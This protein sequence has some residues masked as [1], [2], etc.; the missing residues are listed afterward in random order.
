MFAGA[1]TEGYTLILRSGCTLSTL[2]TRRNDPRPRPGRRPS[3]SLDDAPR[4]ASRLTSD[5]ASRCLDSASTTDVHVTSTRCRHH[6]WRLPPSAVGKPAG[7][8]LRDRASSGEVSPPRPLLDAGP[9]RGHPASS[10]CVLDGTRA[11]FGSIDSSHGARLGELPDAERATRPR[12]PALFRLTGHP[13]DRDPLAPLCR[14]PVPGPAN[15]PVPDRLITVHRG[16]VN[17]GRLLR[18][19]GTFHRT[20]PDPGRSRESP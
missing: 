7:V 5:T 4:W 12:A 3:T 9:P 16:R 14:R 18:D 17:A 19:R 10:G 6:L 15:G 8:Q 2:A 11:G 13:V 1:F 20:G